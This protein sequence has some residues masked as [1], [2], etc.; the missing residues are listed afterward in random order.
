MRDRVHA[1]NVWQISISSTVGSHDRK[2]VAFFVSSCLFRPLAYL[3]VTGRVPPI[4]D[5]SKA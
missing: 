5:K 3:L 2:I 1:G 4:K